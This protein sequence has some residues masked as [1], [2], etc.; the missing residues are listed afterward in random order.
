MTDILMTMYQA[1]QQSMFYAA[2]KAPTTFDE[3]EA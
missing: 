1:Q 2:S 3:P